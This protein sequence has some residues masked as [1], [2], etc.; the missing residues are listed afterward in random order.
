MI[1]LCFKVLKIVKICYR[2]MIS[3]HIYKKV[4][5]KSTDKFE[6]VFVK[7]YVS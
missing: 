7:N 4:F 1:F 2:L 5:L 6:A 3:N